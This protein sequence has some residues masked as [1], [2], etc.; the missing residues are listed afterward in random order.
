MIIR[1]AKTEDLPVL[2]DFEQKIIEVERPMDPTIKTE[3]HINYYDLNAYIKA[4]DTEVAVIEIEG[5]IVGG[6]YGQI[7]S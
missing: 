2:L 1:Q 4:D 3:S 7:R 6:G 5:E